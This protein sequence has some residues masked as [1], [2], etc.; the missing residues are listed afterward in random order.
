VP[1]KKN[2]DETITTLG[3]FRHA[4]KSLKDGIQIYI[5]EVG[6]DLQPLIE[7]TEIQLILPKKI[8]DEPFIVL[9]CI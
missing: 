4:T 1:K 6:E 2:L 8:G 7:V 5:Q 3:D 9:R